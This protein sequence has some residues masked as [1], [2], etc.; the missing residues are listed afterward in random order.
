MLFAGGLSL[1]AMG[2]PVVL[3]AAAAITAGLGLALGGGVPK[4][5]WGSTAAVLLASGY[6]AWRMATSPV[7]DL[8]RY[9]WLLLT[10]V[11]CAW[12]TL[13]MAPSEW[14]L[15]RT[16]WLVLG[17]SLLAQVGVACYQFWG[18]AA[19]TPIYRH[20]PEAPYGSGFYA[21][22]ND[23]GPF[24][25][26]A[27][28]PLLALVGWPGV[29][30]WVRGAAALL[31]G[32]ALVGCFTAQARG[33]LVG[34]AAGTAILIV[35]WVC[36]PQAASGKRF[37]A[38]AL[39]LP[40]LIFGGVK[41]TSGVLVHRQV[42]EGVA[43]MLGY[44]DRLFYAA[45]AFE[46]VIERPW[47]GAGSQSYSYEHVRFWPVGDRRYLDDPK[48]VHNEFMQTVTDYGLIGLVLMLVAVG[49]IWVG[50][51]TAERCAADHAKSA[52]GQALRA[53]SL[54]GMVVLGVAALFS[55]NFHLLPTLLGLG[56]FA[57]LGL[58]RGS[59]DPRDPRRW[60]LVIG[61]LL[62]GG[63]AIPVA[64]REAHAWWVGR[65]YWG[66]GSAEERHAALEA[67]LAASPSFSNYQ[68]LGTRHLTR[69]A[70]EPDVYAR[71]R[72]LEQA[73]AAFGA[74]SE[75][76]PMHW[77]TL[78]NRA[79]VLDSLGRF[80]L[81]EPHHAKVAELGDAREYWW[82][83]RF[84]R[85]RH[86]DLWARSI[87]AQRRPEEALWLLHRARAEFAR[88]KQL[89]RPA[90]GPGSAEVVEQNAATIKL[91]ETARVQ[92]RRPDFLPEEAGEKSRAK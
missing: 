35:L 27:L 47:V 42:G 60:A 43:D 14:Q 51:V 4:P 7:A 71:R 73:E 58:P 90:D 63:A 45:L 46:Q 1:E 61:L 76:H 44:N 80:E 57:A 82:H 3:L 8:A 48:W 64:A 19:F 18:D 89:P 69:A 55:F 75:R 37:A 29:K 85:G 12:A 92:P 23:L 13:R 39:A 87:W 79:N 26:A 66:D 9:D 62:I 34:L 83:A 72:A 78:L 67:M 33:S 52:V 81:A 54:A 77:E 70:A 65:A 16:L 84:Y 91:L 17:V 20:R 31:A 24:L 59:A 11:L 50:G 10:G 49:W 2:L 28:M 86:Y 25:A 32:A 30:R 21:R 38:L 53:G 74:A 15:S 6:F 68:L 88:A 56:F 5:F 40:V 41:I 36:L 22:Y